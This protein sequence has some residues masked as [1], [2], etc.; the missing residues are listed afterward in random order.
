MLAKSVNA[1]G[2]RIV[3]YNGL[4]WARSGTVEI[5]GHPGRFIFV[6]DVPANGYKTIAPPPAADV[7]QPQSH[8]TDTLNTPFYKVIFDLQRG[9]IASLVDKKTGRE[10]VEQSSPYALGQFLHE[11][12]DNQHMGEYNQRY[13]RNGYNFARADL[14]HDQIYAKLTPPSWSID[15][16]STALADIATLTATDTIGLAKGIAIVVTLYHNQP[17]VDVEWRVT[18]KTPDPVPEGG[19]LCF[20]FAITQPQ[21]TLGRLGGPIDPTRDIVPGSNRS[22]INLATGLTIRG[23]DQT[24]I[25]LCPV[26]S[27]FVSLDHPGLWEY[28]LDYEP[29]I[30]TVFVNLYNN[31]W[32]TNFPEWQDGS[33]TSRVRLWPTQGDD[34]LRN[35]VT[36]S[37]DA[38]LPLLAVSADGPAGKLPATQ[39]GLALSRGGVLVTAFGADPDGVNQGTLLRVWEQSGITG[40]TTVILPPGFKASTAAPVDLRGQKLGD[41]MPIQDGK[42]IFN[43][44]AYAPASFMIN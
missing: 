7:D 6:E 19:W 25:G 18:D 5:P 26:D 13:S 12:F 40:K 28:S 23:N 11:R 1:E 44:H 9:G 39:T 3:V 41:P 20:P 31:M 16:Q 29:K 4:P 15:I 42:L 24:G 8:P 2:S 35:M 33:W 30:P 34:V 17:G 14:P 37:W 27:P 38:R 32:N 10:L 22:Y 43:L 21:F 36:P